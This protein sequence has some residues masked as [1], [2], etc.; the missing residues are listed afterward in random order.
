M[1][2]IDVVHPMKLLIAARLADLTRAL[3]EL[4]ENDAEKRKAPLIEIPHAR[5]YAQPGEADWLLVKILSRF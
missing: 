3:D 5:R 4:P 2:F 1:R